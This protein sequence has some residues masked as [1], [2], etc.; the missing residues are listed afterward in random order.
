MKK[1]YTEPFITQC[2]DKT[3]KVVRANSSQNLLI[4]IK[5]SKKTQKLIH[6]VI[7]EIVRRVVVTGDLVV[8]VVARRPCCYPVMKSLER[9]N[10]QFRHLANFIHWYS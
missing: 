8:I 10:F 7:M 3:P 4:S 9:I 2:I 1:N 5:Q 6:S